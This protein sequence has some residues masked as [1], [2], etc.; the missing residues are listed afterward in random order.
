MCTAS[1]Q[2]RSEV[3]TTATLKGK[4][5][6]TLSHKAFASGKTNT[7]HIPMQD[8]TCSAHTVGITTVRAPIGC[9][10]A[11]SI[12]NWLFFST[13]EIGI[14]RLFCRTE[15]RMRGGDAYVT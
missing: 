7:T 5:P 10:E 14:V 13:I 15:I 2:N 6:Q 12:S 4:A 9:R 11:F 8:I 3:S 1:S